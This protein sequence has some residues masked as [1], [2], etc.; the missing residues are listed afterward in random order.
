MGPGPE[1]LPM[2]EGAVR[3]PALTDARAWA[4]VKCD[5]ENAGFAAHWGDGFPCREP[6]E[7]A[8]PPTEVKRQERRVLL[9]EYV[10]AFAD[11]QVRRGGCTE[12]QLPAVP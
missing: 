1:P 11:D 7:K 9:R 12:L 2:G 4:V 10:A 6:G 3:K 5:G 8:G